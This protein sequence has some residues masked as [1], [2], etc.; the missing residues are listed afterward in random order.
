M[1]TYA[2]N[3]RQVLHF[4]LDRIKYSFLTDLHW[5]SNHLY[6]LYV[7]LVIIST[8][9][10]APLVLGSWRFWWFTTFILYEWFASVRVKYCLSSLSF[11]TWKSLLLINIIYLQIWFLYSRLAFQ[12]VN[13]PFYFAT[14]LYKAMKGAGTTDTTVIRILITRSE[15]RL[16]YNF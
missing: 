14:R 4:I 13:R 12:A 7:I 9:L 10:F 16:V 8:W 2:K 1:Y 6:K 15:V 11:E 5:S 3:K